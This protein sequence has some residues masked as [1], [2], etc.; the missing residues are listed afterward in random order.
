MGSR[1]GLWFGARARAK[2]LKALMAAVL[3][4]VSIIYVRRSL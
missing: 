3:I 1:G 2:W 4:M